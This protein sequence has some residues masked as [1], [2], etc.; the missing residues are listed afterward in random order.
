[1]APSNGL[2]GT[3]SGTSIWCSFLTFL[4]YPNSRW[5]ARSQVANIKK[6]ATLL[7]NSNW[8]SWVFG[9]WNFLSFLD[10]TVAGW[11]DFLH[12][13]W[14]EIMSP[15]TPGRFSP[16]TPRSASTP[17]EMGKLIRWKWPQFDEWVRVTRITMK[18]IYIYIQIQQMC[19]CIIFVMILICDDMCM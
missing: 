3:A 19:T 1:M 10:R 5:K 4:G 18:Q 11:L 8:R 2:K 15:Q 6:I 12:F 13:G 17:S 16:E 9:H 14:W 7:P